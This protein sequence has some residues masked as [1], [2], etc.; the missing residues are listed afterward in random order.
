MFFDRAL[1]GGANDSRFIF[2]GKLRWY[3]D[4]EQNLA[5]HARV[6]VHFQALDN[7][8]ALSGDAALLAKTQD[9]YTGARADGGQ[10][11]GERCRG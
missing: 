5:D 11:C 2:L 4:V 8:H 3:L 9:V 7:A 1:I 10:E 6:S